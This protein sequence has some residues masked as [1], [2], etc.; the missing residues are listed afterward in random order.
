MLG[1]LMWAA[2]IAAVAIQAGCGG[3]SD[4]KPNVP[5]EKAPT[6]EKIEPD[7]PQ[8][9]PPPR[10]PDA[11]GIFHEPRDI[12]VA[13]DGSLYVADFGN[14][15]IQKLDAERQLI[16]AWG[17]QGDGPGKFN[18]PCGVAVDPSGHLWVADTFNSR[19][20]KFSP[21]NKPIVTIVELGPKLDPGRF[22]GPRGIAID[23]DGNLY[24]TDTGSHRVVKLSPDGKVVGAWGRLK[25]DPKQGDGEGE[26]NE[27]VGIA[28]APDGSVYVCDTKNAR[29]Q[30]FTADGKFV[31]QWKMDG[32]SP[33]H[34]SEAYVDVGADGTVWVTDPPAHRVLHLTA[35][36]EQIAVLT[37]DADGKR[38]NDPRGIAVSNERGSVYVVNKGS[39]NIVELKI[40]GADDA[41][42]GGGSEK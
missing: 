7:I 14:D 4:D 31:S 19:I 12:A 17:G 42:E 3:R 33:K 15:R 13:P 38:L 26:F 8:P 6:D 22:S 41:A 27:P 35:D 28:V 11:P 23:A 16:A 25:G 2:L 5:V 9:P 34:S 18:D 32:W 40:P 30:R 39:Q 20:I 10:V 1:K 29:V 36:G 37:T 24:V 21:D